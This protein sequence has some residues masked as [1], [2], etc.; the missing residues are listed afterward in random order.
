MREV[1]KL[2][3]YTIHQERMIRISREVDFSN[4]FIPPSYFED[5][6]K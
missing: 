4:G 2:S 5:E 6:K 1:F 3:E